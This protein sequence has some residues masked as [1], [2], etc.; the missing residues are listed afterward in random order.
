MVATTYIDRTTPSLPHRYLTSGSERP[1]G[2]FM[3]N[4]NH[5]FYPFLVESHT[6]A[7]LL[8]HQ[9][10]ANWAHAYEQLAELMRTELMSFDIQPAGEPKPS[11]TEALRDAV[12]SGK[13]QAELERFFS[14]S[15][16]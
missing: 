10:G 13:V 14:E 6:G 9:L 1:Y 5:S 3:T 12:Y 11:N 15:G 8:R 2:L 4:T 16:R 7:K